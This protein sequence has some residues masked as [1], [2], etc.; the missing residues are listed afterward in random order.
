M[1][2]KLFGKNRDDGGRR[3]RKDAGELTIADFDR[4]PA[5]EF[6]LDEEGIEGQDECTVR[7]FVPRG[8]VDPRE[9]D[10]FIPADATQADGT[11]H[12]GM[13]FPAST[14]L[15]GDPYRCELWLPK[16]AGEYGVTG[17]PTGWSQIVRAKSNRIGFDLA[18]EEH[19]PTAK[20]R[21][22]IELVYQVLR[23]TK[24][25]MWPMTFTPRLQV[26]G[27]PAQIQLQGWRRTA[28]NEVLI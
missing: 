18:M 20:V 21:A 8:V 9:F 22:Q 23:T 16:A 15:G 11:R 3:I 17:L 27:W 25:R 4:F 24:D 1:F 14:Y 6:C 26:K 7:P 28:T 5:W 2:G 10:G 12:I 19:F 13:L